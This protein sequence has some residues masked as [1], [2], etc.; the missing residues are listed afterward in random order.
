MQWGGGGVHPLQ[1]GTMAG[2][3]SSSPSSSSAF[4][5][6]Y[7]LIGLVVKASTSGAED[8]RFKSRLRRDFFWVES[9]Q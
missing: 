2:F 8:P 7:C 3:A 5:S 1:S 4:P 6:F 9:Y